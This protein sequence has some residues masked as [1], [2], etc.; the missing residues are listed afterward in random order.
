MAIVP[1]PL[2]DKL[3]GVI[4]VIPIR[5]IPPIAPIRGR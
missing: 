2:V 1:N 3:V 5:P 4:R